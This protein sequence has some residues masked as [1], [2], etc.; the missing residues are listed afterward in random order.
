VKTGDYVVDIGTGSGV[1]AIMAAKAGARKVIGVDVNRESIGYARRAAVINNV[2]DRVDFVTRHFSDF[3]P[4]ERADLVICEML[5]SIMLIEQQ[6]AACNHAV[7]SV[8][9]AK[10][11]LI[12]QNA[13]IY[14]VPVESQMMVD[15][16]LFDDIQFPSVVQTISPE[17]TRDLSDAKVLTEFDFTHPTTVS[18]IDKV[19]NFRIV[20]NGTI[21]GLVGLFESRLY[22]EIILTMEDG[23]KQLF[24]PLDT[25]VQVKTGDE[26]SVR[27][28]YTPGEYNSLVV[29]VD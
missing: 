20:G 29:E 12:P 4:D 6:V 14:L 24:L 2:N 27:I 5:S 22:D 16:F 8:M 13:T 26:F 28:A 10:G 18:K 1:L 23:W 21:H 25:C 3:I 11:S 17:S 15:R 19:L 9:K 7:N